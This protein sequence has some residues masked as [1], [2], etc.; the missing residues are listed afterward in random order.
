[1]PSQSDL[2]ILQWRIRCIHKGCEW[3][4]R[5]AA[6]EPFTRHN[7]PAT[8]RTL[9][10]IAGFWEDYICPTHL[11]VQR[12]AMVVNPMGV[13]LEEAQYLYVTG[14]IDTTP[15]PHCP[16]C[17]QEMQSGKVLESLPFTY[18]S[19][20][21]MLKWLI[22]ELGRIKHRID[23]DLHTQVAD[24]AASLRDIGRDM[25]VLAKFYDVMCQNFEINRTV[26]PLLNSTDRTLTGWQATLAENLAILEKSQVQLNHRQAQEA[27]KS[28]AI[29]PACQQQT[30]YLIEAT[31]I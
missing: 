9:D 1:M 26:V 30:V 10:Q 29:C 24:E 25:G 31:T 2:P 5:I 20:L 3:Q 14:H 4:A 8:E 18:Q 27:H 19:S 12:R 6:L 11:E 16:I 13:G 15:V 17:A 21:A 22:G 7:N 23:A 28:P